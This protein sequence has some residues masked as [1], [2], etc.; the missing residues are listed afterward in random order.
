ME[1][2]MCECGHSVKKHGVK[3]CHQTVSGL[4][5]CSCRKAREVVLEYAVTTLRS[6]LGDAMKALEPFAEFNDWDKFDNSFAPIRGKHLTV[7]DLRTAA[8][9]HARI[10]ATLTG[11]E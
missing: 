6:L 9:L 10:K 3:G 5:E 7:G 4:T 2:I 1:D 11:G 8:T